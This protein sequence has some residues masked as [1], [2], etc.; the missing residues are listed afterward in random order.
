MSDNDNSIQDTSIGRDF[1]GRDDN[2]LN[3]NNFHERSVYLQDL[4]GKFQ[5]EKSENQDLREFCE[6]LDYLNSVIDNEVIGLEQ[7]LKNGHREYLIDYAKDVKERFYK[8]L[9][10]TS[11][12]SNV[13]QDINIYLLTKVRR[14]FMMEIYKLICDNESQEKINL[15]ITER[16]INPVKI[17]L[18]INLFRYNEDDIMG[19]IFFLTGNCHIKW[20]K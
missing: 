17:E 4:Y 16:I 19:M 15:L 18:G 10:Q 2:S 11:Q 6:E 14:G 5:K 1:I 8:K 12:Y 13:A 3:I 7:K 9:I 20:S